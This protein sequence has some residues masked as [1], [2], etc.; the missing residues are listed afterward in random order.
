MFATQRWSAHRIDSR[1]GTLLGRIDDVISVSGHR[2]STIEPE[3]AL[4]AHFPAYVP[5]SERARWAATPA[6]A[7]RAPA[8]KIRVPIAKTCGGIPTLTAP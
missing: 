3:S 5:G 8:R 4:V 2:L 6:A 7:V 1:P